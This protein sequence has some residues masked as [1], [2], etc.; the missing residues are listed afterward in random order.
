MRYEIR[1]GKFG[2]YFFDVEK[3][4]DMALADV[5]AVLNDTEQLPPSAP[6]AVEA[7]RA[8][9]LAEIDEALTDGGAWVGGRLDSIRRLIAAHKPPPPTLS[10]DMPETFISGLG[11]VRPCRVCGALVAGGPTACGRCVAAEEVKK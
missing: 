11:T 9:M 1:T 10:P 6:A 8:D 3:E 7:K 5:L 2:Q 4:E